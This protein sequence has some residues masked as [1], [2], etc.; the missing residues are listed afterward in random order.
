M[1]FRSGNWE[2]PRGPSARA[3]PQQRPRRR[4]SEPAADAAHAQTTET[5][6][7]D[8]CSHNNRKS[9]GETRASAGK[10]QNKITEVSWGGIGCGSKEHACVGR[11]LPA[12]PKNRK[13]GG[14]LPALVSFRGSSLPPSLPLPR[15]SPVRPMLSLSWLSVPQR[16][17]SRPQVSVSAQAAPCFSPCFGMPS[18]R[19]RL[20]V[21]STCPYTPRSAGRHPN[22]RL[23]IANTTVCIP[24]CPASKIVGC[25][26]LCF[27]SFVV[28]AFSLVSRCFSSPRCKRCMRLGEEL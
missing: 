19:P 23:F 14:A 16:L 25:F 1:L 28:F 20:G 24:I 2:Q 26:R 3:D 10:E 6:P 22:S 18:A 5:G 27:Y 17:R 4:H 21:H 13:S 11:S 7:L 9:L 12:F 8:A 15:A